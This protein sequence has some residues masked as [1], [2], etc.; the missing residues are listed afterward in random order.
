MDTSASAAQRWPPSQSRGSCRRGTSPAPAG[1][2]GLRADHCLPEEPSSAAATPCRRPRHSG[3][4]HS[5][6]DRRA[7][8]SPPSGR[9][10]ASSGRRPR[11]PASG[12]HPETQAA[13]FR[14][15]AASPAQSIHFSCVFPHFTH[16]VFLPGALP[17]HSRACFHGQRIAVKISLISDCILCDYT[18]TAGRLPAKRTIFKKIFYIPVKLRFLPLFRP[19]PWRGSRPRTRPGCSWPEALRRSPPRH[20]RSSC[21]PA[22][23]GCS[24][25]PLRPDPASRA[26]G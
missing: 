20:A 2:S 16:R 10:P 24:G 22:C 21:R 6:P 7:A 3:A 12:S 18:T 19:A 4:A 1:S 8:H 15:I 5:P 17:F 13:N 11:P 14:R 26:W 25:G 9:R 23:R